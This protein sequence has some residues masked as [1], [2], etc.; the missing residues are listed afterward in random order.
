MVICSFII[1]CVVTSVLRIYYLVRVLSER[2]D[3]PPPLVN[4]ARLLRL[5]GTYAVGLHLLLLALE[6]LFASKRSMTYEKESNTPLILLFVLL[7]WVLAMAIIYLPQ[8]TK[9]PS[10]VTISSYI[11]SYFSSIL[12]M[13]HVR[14]TNFALWKMNR[15]LLKVSH[16]YQVRENIET[17]LSLCRCFIIFSIQTIIGW[18]GLMVYSLLSKQDSMSI[19]VKVAGFIFDISF[20]LSPITIAV[21]LYLFN[22]KVRSA[23]RK[24]L[25]AVLRLRL[26]YDRHLV[27]LD[28]SN[29]KVDVKQQANTYFMQLNAA[30]K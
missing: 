19:A 25:N 23:C 21:V 27:G 8:L 2:F 12:I 13:M 22:E 18:I 10:A 5:G 7:L 24:Q 28:G 14:R 4:T 9:I 30:W 16:N 26:D 15:G 20:A 11:L 3:E 1:S 6:R 17:A 29:L